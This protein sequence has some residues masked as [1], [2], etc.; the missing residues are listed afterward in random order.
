MSV[1]A[2]RERMAGKIAIVTGG[3]GGIGAATG[4]LFCASG[5]R[6]VLADQNEELLRHTAAAIRQRVVGAQVET[7]ACDVADYDDALRV[8]QRAGTAFG[9]V[10][11]L[12]SNAAIRHQGPIESASVEDW[13]RLLNTNLIGAANFCRASA[14][15]LRKN[16]NA[17]VVIVSSC[18]AVIGRKEM[19]IYDATKAALLSLM[20][21]FAWDGA[22]NNVRVNAVCPGGTITPY[23]LE[24]GR[25]AGKSGDDI[26]SERK[27]NSLLGRRAEAVEIAYPI[28]FLAS[29]EASYITGATLM[30]DAGLS[31]M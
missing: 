26:R 11:V 10:N 25:R 18:Y 31:I 5:A 8:V 29:D 27:G 28:M 20:R 19:P 21:S 15:E 1:P 7:V 3:A 30:V 14:P 24:L 4:E 23:T 22:E 17:S 12:V 13:A 9:G 6:V 2:T 16:G